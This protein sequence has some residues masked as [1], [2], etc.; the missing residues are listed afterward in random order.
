MKDLFGN[1]PVRTLGLYQPYATL[2]LHGKIESRWVQEGKKAPFPLGKYLIYSTKKAYTVREFEHVAGEYSSDAVKLFS[3]DETLDLYGYA[4]AI[5]DLVEVKKMGMG[6]I[7]KAFIDI[8]LTM[9]KDAKE[10]VDLWEEI[11]ID[12]ST[13]WGLHFK[14]VKRIKPFPFKGKQG[15]GFLSTEDQ[16]KIEFV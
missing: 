2:M 6:E 11:T 12:E 16:S 14:S 1:E 15:V 9:L 5:G 13:L 7:P 4:L 3:G 8:N 10:G